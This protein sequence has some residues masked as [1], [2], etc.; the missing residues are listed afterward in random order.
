MTPDKIPNP[1]HMSPLHFAIKEN[2]TEAARLL[3]EDP[4][5]DVNAKAHGILFYFIFFL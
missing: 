1:H 4:R 5:I 3:L 2:S